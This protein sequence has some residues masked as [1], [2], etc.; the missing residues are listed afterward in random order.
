MEKGT[1]W[2]EGIIR[3]WT[4]RQLNVVQTRWRTVSLGAQDVK[5]RP[6]GRLEAGVQG[7]KLL[8]FSGG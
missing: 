7:A 5:I 6:D 2:A 3:E 8:G 1:G 4:G